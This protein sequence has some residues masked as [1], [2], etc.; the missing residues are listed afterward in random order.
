MP[1]VDDGDD[2]DLPSDLDDDEDD[3]E[4]DMGDVSADDD[5]DDD[6][7]DD[8]IFPGGESDE[9]DSDTEIPVE[10]LVDFESG[11]EAAEEE[12]WTGISQ[13]QND[14]KRRRDSKSDGKQKKKLR[15]LPTFAS[16]EDYEKMID[17][18]PEDM[19]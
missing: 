5:D 17:A 12:E 10:G 18:T 13:S 19:L 6:E 2:D 7:D 11:S 14:K 3:N 4:P 8:V 15:S 16:L 9:I 1:Q